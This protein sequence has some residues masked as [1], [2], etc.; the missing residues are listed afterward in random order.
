MGESG[1]K[2]FEP[3]LTGTWQDSDEQFLWRV[4]LTW[5]KIRRELAALPDSPLKQAA[6]KLYS[7]LSA[8]AAMILRMCRETELRASALVVAGLL[9]ILLDGCASIFA[10]AKDPK[11]RA[12]LY[13]NF[14]A[15]LDFDFWCKAERL[16]GCPC[17]WEDEAA[18]E[19]MM[20]RKAKTAESLYRFGQDY[21]R[22]QRGDAAS[23]LAEA[24]AEGREK[25]KSFRDKWYPES[26]RKILEAEKMEWLFELGY[27]F[28][29]SAVHADPVGSRLLAG[30][31]RSHM[32]TQVIE[33]YGAGLY[34]LV[35]AV[36]IQLSDE[37]EGALQVM[38]EKLQWT[39]ANDR[40]G[41][42]QRRE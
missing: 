18:W 9:R 28:Y 5:E 7:D 30:F 23:R 21:L 32:A 24:L 26:R 35:E 11:K 20:Q 4:E 41:Q 36:E 39:A 42:S 14:A 37:D 31:D 3:V 38:Y 34:K 19:I 16:R 25:P 12:E 15:V 33:Y 10:F 22:T 6:C 8:P 29:S 2:P 1:S 17:I 27:Q 13:L 40:G